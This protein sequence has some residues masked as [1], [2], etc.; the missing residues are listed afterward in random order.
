VMVS[1]VSLFCPHSHWPILSH[2]RSYPAVLAHS[3]YEG[4]R[5]GK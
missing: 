2:D 3:L 4:L 1:V 5:I